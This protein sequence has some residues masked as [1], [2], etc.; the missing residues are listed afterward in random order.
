MNKEDI[1]NALNELD[2]EVLEKTEKFRDTKHG[3]RVGIMQKSRFGRILA[4]AAAV[5]ILTGGTILAVHLIRAGKEE[6]PAVTLTTPEPSDS[7][8][9][10]DTKDTAET[11]DTSDTEI[12]GETE[13]A[14]R[15]STEASSDQD[16]TEEG[17]E[18]DSTLESS[19]QGT[20][21]DSTKESVDQST[22]EDAE[23]EDFYS[24][25][26]DEG[27]RMISRFESYQPGVNDIQILLEN[28]SGRT[29]TINN[30]VTLEIEV[31]EGPEGATEYTIVPM[32]E[33]Y[34]KAMEERGIDIE[35][36]RQG[37]TTMPSGPDSILP[38]FW[39]AHFMTEEDGPLALGNYRLTVIINGEE[40]YFPFKVAED[41][42][43]GK[44]HSLKELSGMSAI[45]C[46]EK[47]YYRSNASQDA[48]L[49]YEE[50]N[51]PA[52][53]YLGQ[54]AL[55]DSGKRLEKDLDAY[56]L[57]GWKVYYDAANDRLLIAN[58]KG[59]SEEE[60]TYTVFRETVEVKE[61][62]TWK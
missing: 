1:T 53:E 13:S 29:L 25:V 7:E 39:S 31:Q 38:V 52:L 35:G 5:L 16:S 34:R 37:T 45:R 14:D 57:K 23:E 58:G 21:Q 56:R 26:Y 62:E 6:T 51:V 54:T 17:T 8:D 48:P 4:A 12:T 61:T 49:T 40:K 24:V 47:I 36:S 28:N 9:T 3:N 10:A 33:H 27:Y 46:K 50:A 60:D 2:D 59:K 19:D 22:A 32:G 41:G 15:D 42:W 30:G 43:D 20:E 11:E 55:T 44:P 18:Q